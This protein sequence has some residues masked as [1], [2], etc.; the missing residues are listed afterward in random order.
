MFTSGSTG[1]VHELLLHPHRHRRR[2]RSA[3]GHRI[4]A[5]EGGRVDSCAPSSSDV[6]AAVAD[7]VDLGLG[8]SPMTCSLWQ[9]LRRRPLLVWASGRRRSTRAP[10]SIDRARVP[11]PCTVAHSLDRCNFSAALSSSAGDS[12]PQIG[13]VVAGDRSDVMFQLIRVRRGTHAET[14]ADSRGGRQRSAAGALGLRGTRMGRPEVPLQ[15]VAP[16]SASTRWHLGGVFLCV[17]VV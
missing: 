14:V 15:W 8:S 3:P 16:R 10:P 1:T 4:A 17:W 5:Q 12:I 9:S 11:M 13:A 7:D 6:A 2:H